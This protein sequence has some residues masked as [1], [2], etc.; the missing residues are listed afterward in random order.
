M[1]A[2]ALGACSVADI[3]SDNPAIASA[4][5][6]FTSPLYVYIG[7]SVWNNQE[8]FQRATTQFA[9]RREELIS[10]CMRDAGFTYRPDLD[11]DRFTIGSAALAD[12]HSNDPEW[13]A[14]Y[15]FG[16]ISGH[17]PVFGAIL[18]DRVDPNKEYRESLSET[19]RV[20]YDFALNGPEDNLQPAWTTQDDHDEWM[21]SR[22]CWGR[23]IVQAQSES[24]LFLRQSDEFAPLW[25]AIN[26]MERA[27]FE[28][29]EIV[30][31]HRDWSSCM[32]GAGHLGLGNPSDARI[33]VRTEF[34]VTRTTIDLRRKAGTPDI[35]GGAALL[36]DIQRREIDMALVDFDCRQTNDFDTRVNEIRLEA[37]TQFV[38][39]NRALLEDF[40]NAAEVA[41]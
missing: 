16:I 22:G 31:L 35:D 25:D 15:G 28:R 21:K 18:G 34:L 2:F 4:V 14:Q 38:N 20:A 39:D 33:T 29:P 11:S 41:G 24:P 40:R 23:A 8:E 37:E 10:K 6:D 26:D 32:A 9:V 3:I 30:K 12:I 27:I 1:V 36:A 13:V 19:A 17:N 7:Q 5:T